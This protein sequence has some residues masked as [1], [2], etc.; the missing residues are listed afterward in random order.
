MSI[1]SIAHVFQS[2]NLHWKFKDGYRVPTVEE[3]D[4]AVIRA[5]DAL[6]DE[7]DLTQI[8][9]G[10]MIVQKNGQAYDVYVQMHEIPISDA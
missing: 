10:R 9:F 3:I 4:D 1:A 8:E 7:A 6:R 5:M 2:A